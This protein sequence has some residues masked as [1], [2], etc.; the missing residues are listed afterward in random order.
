MKTLLTLTFLLLACQAVVV[1]ADAPNASNASK[2]DAAAA[3]KGPTV[4]VKLASGKAATSGTTA[5]GS[6]ASEYAPKSKS[7]FTGSA[8]EHNPFW[9]IGWIKTEN[10]ST[11]D[12]AP[13]VPRAE[14]FSVTTIMLNEPPMAVINGKDMAE[15][16]IASLNVGGQPVVV[17]LMAVQDGRVTLRWQNQSITVGIHRNEILSPADTQAPPDRLR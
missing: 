2:A 5:S 12:T 1:R 11:S 10:Y 15:G 16:E 6:A 4:E 14:D 3:K 13:Y 9:P 17:Q 8:N 7:V